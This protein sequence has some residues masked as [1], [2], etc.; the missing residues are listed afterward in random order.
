MPPA[1]AAPS[2]AAISGL[3]RRRPFSSGS[4]TEGSNLPLRNESA[5]GAAAMAFRSAPAQKAPP[6]PVRMQARMPGSLSTRSQAAAMIAIIGPLRAL[7]AC[8]R[9]MVT[10]RT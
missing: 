4:I 3:V 8:G 1:I 2:T 9:F 6:A 7:R 5:G 10:I